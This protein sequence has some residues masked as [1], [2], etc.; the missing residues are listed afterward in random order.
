MDGICGVSVLFCYQIN[1]YACTPTGLVDSCGKHAL[2]EHGRVCKKI[3]VHTERFQVQDFC[4]PISTY[5]WRCLC[6]WCYHHETAAR[7]RSFRVPV[8]GCDVHTVAVQPRRA[9][10]LVDK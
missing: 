9:A 5:H 10:V 7:A 3:I 2:D 8:G 6:V 4:I 1:K